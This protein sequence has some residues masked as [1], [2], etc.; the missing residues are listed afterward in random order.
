MR[1]YLSRIMSLILATCFLI[2]LGVAQSDLNH[3][4]L[5][6]RQEQKSRKKRKKASEDAASV[7]SQWQGS[8]RSTEVAEDINF[9]LTGG[10][11]YVSPNQTMRLDSAGQNGGDPFDFTE[12]KMESVLSEE[13]RR[14]LKL[15][16][17]KQ[18]RKKLNKKAE[19]YPLQLAKI[20]LQETYLDAIQIMNPF[21]ATGHVFT[22]WTAKGP[23]IAT[24]DDKGEWIG[25]AIM[26]NHNQLPAGIL[27]EMKE[28]KLD[29]TQ[30]E[31]RL[32][33]TT[34]DLRRPVYALY[35]SQTD[36]V[37]DTSLLNEE[38]NLPPHAIAGVEVA[39][40]GKHFILGAAIH[41]VIPEK[42]SFI[43]V[44]LTADGN[45]VLIKDTE[46]LFAAQLMIFPSHFPLKNWNPGSGWTAGKQWFQLPGWE[47]EYT[48][49]Y[50]SE[51][52]YVELY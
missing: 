49:W 14:A 35:T 11:D 3:N 10:T 18:A 17:L 32:K 44:M 5:H 8:T 37:N 7:A 24:Y 6:P 36:L 50:P 38:Q 23:G 4:P 20:H 47:P 40:L 52:W 13:E 39:G 41:E 16:E 1:R 21:S 42:L 45:P 19:D 27:R 33:I 28:L 25:T 26:L 2:P 9:D 12:E 15:A 48:R 31:D 46:K 29:R 30:F 22:F 34:R 43:G 51:D